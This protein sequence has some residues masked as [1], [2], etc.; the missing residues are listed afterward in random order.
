MVV[1]VATGVKNLTDKFS[2][3]FYVYYSYRSYSNL[4]PS[5]AATTTPNNPVQTI[6]HTSPA[7]SSDHFN[8]L[9][10]NNDS[11]IN[12][13]RKNKHSHNIMTS[14]NNNN[15][16]QQQLLQQP[17]RG[18]SN[19]DIDPQLFPQTRDGMLQLYSSQRRWIHIASGWSRVG[20]G[21]T[22][23]Q[24]TTTTT[25]QY[26]HRTSDSRKGTSIDS[27]D[28]D[29]EARAVRSLIAQLCEL[30][31][32]TGGATGTAGGV[33]IRVGG[34]SEHRP[35]RVFVAPSGIQKEDM[36]GDDIFEMDMEK[37]IVVPSKTDG[38][39]LSACTPLWYVVYRNR[40]TANAVIHTHSIHAMLAT[41]LDP[42]ETSSVLQITHME[43]L[44]GVGHHAYDDIIEIPIIDN[45]PSEDML[46]DQLEWAIQQYPKCNCVLVRRHGL[47]VWGDSWEQAKTQLESFEYLFQT[48]VEMKKLGL[49]CSIV[50]KHGSFR[51]DEGNDSNVVEPPPKKRIKVTTNTTTPTSTTTTT[52]A[53]G[54]N[55]VTMVD[56]ASD[57]ST[58]TVPIL[59]RDAK[60]LLLDIE[61]CTTAISFVKDT[62]FPYVIE[63]IDSYVKTLSTN[64]YNTLAEALWGD[65]STSHQSKVLESAGNDDETNNVLQDCSV[66][67]KYMVANDLKLA[68][69]KSMQ[70]QMWKAG[71]ENGSLKGHVYNDFVPML[72]WM[73]DQGVKVYIYSSGS[74]QA[75][76]LLFGYSTDG[77]LLEY[78]HGHYDIT[79]AGNKMDS[80][81][82]TTICNDLKI[83]P[84]ELV[85]CSDAELELAAAQEAGVGSTV[86]TV[87]PG[88]APLTDKGKT[89]Y[90]QV[91][92]LL[93]LCGS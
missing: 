76:K 15:N 20:G 32:R 9:F 36:V 92:S 54:W 29:A 64:D 47:Y 25:D 79:T 22:D 81:S 49:D 70:G 51:V 71:Y 50:P 19:G 13:N 37:N 2:K 59:P 63:H 55:G 68:S 80:N 91:L 44:K 3:A 45:R 17:G 1:V 7:S 88:N 11:I 74:I 24:S 58:N 21:S 28:A 57:L 6:Y 85:F 33:S 93:Q 26:S 83:S 78:I 52:T 39:K 60:Y 75:Q 34:P 67:V 4:L 35:Y 87:R 82:Y 23:D 46:E 65:L 86:M 8:T 69:L 27:H 41:L 62:L 53:N 30:L 72:R 48:A 5:I 90:P 16:E 38:L 43:M 66:L 84:S 14:N 40:P 10:H 89:A 56:N 18:W 73:R 61:G 77:D 12:S 42:T 31:Y